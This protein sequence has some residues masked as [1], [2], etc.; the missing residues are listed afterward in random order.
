MQ[1]QEEEVVFSWGRVSVLLLPTRTPPQP[2]PLFPQSHQH[3]PGIYSVNN[4]C[5]ISL[6][7]PS[8]L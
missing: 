2:H 8:S 5:M 6:K 3:F 1:L 7:L 4:E